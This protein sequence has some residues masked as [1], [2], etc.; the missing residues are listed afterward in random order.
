MIGRRATAGLALLCALLFSAF[1]VQSASAQVGKAATNT[2]AFTCVKGG[3]N[4]DFKDAHCDEF[5]GVE[6]GEYGHELIPAG[7][8]AIEVTNEGTSGSKTETAL[9][10]VLTTTHL[11][12][13]VEISCAVVSSSNS[14]IQNVDSK[15]NKH[16]VEGTVKVE[17][18]KCTTV[19]PAKCT[20][21]EPIPT[22]AKFKGVEGLKTGEKANTMGVEFT[23][24]EGK[25]F[26]EITF[27]GAECVFKGKTFPVTGTAIATG[28]PAPTEK[29]SGATSV[30]VPN[31]KAKAED[32][33]ETL[34]FS[35]SE[36][37]FKGTFTTRMAEKGNPITLTTVT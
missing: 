13:G 27:E 26:A 4:L 19:K 28:K 2:T 12:V 25:N 3:G 29:H 15:E 6:K 10:A 20:V 33:M 23:Q 5:V 31:A 9:P 32:E 18:S 11:A 24:D 35:T 21:K 17:F 36:A 8:T 30:Y 37:G 34:K 16:T 22:V 1:A 14:W 7:T